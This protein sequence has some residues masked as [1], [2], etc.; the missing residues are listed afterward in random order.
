LERALVG[1]CV[2]VGRHDWWNQI[3]ISSGLV[4]GYAGK[5]RA[6]DLVKHRGGRSYEFVEL[7]IASNTALYATVEILQYG[8]VWLLSRQFRVRLGYSGDSLLDADD[9]RLNVLAG[10]SYFQ[11]VDFNAFEAGVT[12]AVGEIAAL[13][14]D[15][16]AF[17]M[18]RFPESFVWPAKHTPHALCALLDSL[19]PRESRELVPAIEAA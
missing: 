1:A 8:F 10:K 5:R 14:G 3:P 7:K 11:D 9:V 13:H 16:M 15:S 2:T 6:I 19:F 4:N 18:V 12:S 17:R